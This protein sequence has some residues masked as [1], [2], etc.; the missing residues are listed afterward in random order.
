MKHD[1]ER[2]AAAYL[3]GLLR[4]ARRR[5]FERHILN[6][7]DCWREVD[8]GRKGR[9]VAES[10]RELAPQALRERVRTAVETIRPRPRRPRW[11]F[12]AGLV[13][14][15][16]LLVVVVILLPERDPR[17]IEAAVT[18]FRSGRMGPSA[19]PELPE[20]LGDLELT[21]A[22]HAALEGID[23]VAH[24]YVDAS[25]EEVVVYVAEREWP[26]AVGAEHDGAGESWVAE[27]GGLV[28]IC[29]NEP[30]PSLIVGNDLSVVEL[31]ASS[32]RT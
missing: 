12:G 3:G 10:A 25:G 6:C 23:A 8:L 15:T 13:A 32:L 21:R 9:S 31:A 22:Q 20:H 5:M 17:E 19:Q 27:K 11:I 30:A 24:S 1:P 4:G 28:L 14:L 16:A 18:D 26:V 7:E 29:L 2:N